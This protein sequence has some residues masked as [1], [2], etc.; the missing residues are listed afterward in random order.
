[1]HLKNSLEKMLTFNFYFCNIVDSTQNFNGTSS[2][3]SSIISILI[4]SENDLLY[5]NLILTEN[6]PLHFNLKNDENILLYTKVVKKFSTHCRKC[7]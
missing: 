3:I 6:K 1:M 2:S 4:L 7:L 5:Y